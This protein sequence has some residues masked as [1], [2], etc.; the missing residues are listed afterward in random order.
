MIA[1]HR[2]REDVGF[3]M[4][5]KSPLFSWTRA[6]RTPPLESGSSDAPGTRCL[7]FFIARPSA[8]GTVWSK[9]PWT[10][11]TSVLPALMFTG[12]D[13]PLCP[14]DRRRQGQSGVSNVRHHDRGS[15]DATVL[16][17]GIRMHPRCHGSDRHLLEPVWN[18]LS[19][20]S[21]DL[22]VANAA[23]Q[24]NV[25]GRKTDVND[26][27]WIADLV[28]CGLVRASFVPD[29]AI[30]NFHAAACPQA[31]HPRANPS[32]PADPEDTGGA[33]IKLDSVI[34]DIMGVSGR[35]MIDAMMAGIRNPTSWP[36]SPI[37]GSRRHQRPC[38]TPC[39]D[40]S[41]IIIASCS[42]SI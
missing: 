11:C 8:D 38:T 29:E 25:P 36:N 13:R 19:D 15:P 7:E 17:G 20:G 16:A 32:H 3:S 33:N 9:E 6:P 1:W 34:S 18:I 37:V 2:R 30:Q 21:F 10:S 42:S 12:H 27:M 40:G 5:Q 41:P 14:T 35:R 4:V 39:M 24:Q 28:A 22:I 23:H 31:T 26:A